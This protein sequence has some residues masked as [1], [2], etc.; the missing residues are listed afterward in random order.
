METLKQ[1]SYTLFSHHMYSMINHSFHHSSIVNHQSIMNHDY[2][3][4][5]MTSLSISKHQLF[6]S[7]I[8]K[9]RYQLILTKVMSYPLMPILSKM[10][11]YRAF[12]TPYCPLGPYTLSVGLDHYIYHTVRTLTLHLPLNYLIRHKIGSHIPISKLSLTFEVHLEMT[13]ASVQG[14]SYELMSSTFF[15]FDTF[16]VKLPWRSLIFKTGHHSNA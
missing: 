15:K 13:T 3:V 11:E 16:F 2:D 9:V 4:I 6:N 8:W 12:R 7:E 10:S 14:V 5:P 1:Y